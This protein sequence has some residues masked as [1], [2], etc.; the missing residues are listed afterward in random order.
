MTIGEL[1]EYLKRFDQNLQVVYEVF[2]EQCILKSDEIS[3]AYHCEPRLDG[4][5]QNY[6]KDKPS[7]QYL[8]LPG[9]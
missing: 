3:V 7:Q 2:S 5:V 8:V 4:W 9:N 6:R 1:R